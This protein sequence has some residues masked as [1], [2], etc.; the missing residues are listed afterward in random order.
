[1]VEPNQPDDDP[2]DFQVKKDAA[3][4]FKRAGYKGDM[5]MDNATHIAH[6]SGK[7]SFDIEEAEDDDHKAA[8][9][10]YRNCKYWHQ[11]RA[12]FVEY[13][14]WYE[15]HPTYKLIGCYHGKPT[16]YNSLENGDTDP[17]VT[18]A[19]EFHLYWLKYSRMLQYGFTWEVSEDK[20]KKNALSK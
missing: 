1:M 3:W 7:C 13:M 12:A 18:T 15:N 14:K 6:K 19:E 8:I 20:R 5:P 9:F 2:T 10:K 11:H 4:L 16:D 17:N